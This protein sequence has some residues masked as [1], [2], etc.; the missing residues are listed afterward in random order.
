MRSAWSPTRSMSFDTVFEVWPNC[1]LALPSVLAIDFRS[2]SG[3]LALLIERGSLTPSTF[4]RRA[5]RLSTKPPATPTAAAPTA[6]AGPL[7]LLAA[8]LTV[9]TMPLP[10]WPAPLPLEPPALRFAVEREALLRAREEADDFGRDEPPEERD[11]PLRA[12]LLP[13]RE[14]WLAFA[15]EA[16]PLDVLLLL[17]LLAEADLLVAIRDTSPIENIRFVVFGYP[18]GDAITHMCGELQST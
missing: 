12:P 16:E 5:R 6:T 1:L 4:V 11:V 15:F 14:D 2:R 17:C 9:P 10:F 7:A 13:E 18:L 3:T 8:F